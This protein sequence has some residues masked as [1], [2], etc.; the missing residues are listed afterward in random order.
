MMSPYVD[1]LSAPFVFHFMAKLNV[2]GGTM[3]ASMLG[4]K[5]RNTFATIF[6]KVKDLLHIQINLIEVRDLSSFISLVEDVHIVHV[7][8]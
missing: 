7:V 3:D 2:G 4:G 8:Q 6:L 5:S 1:P